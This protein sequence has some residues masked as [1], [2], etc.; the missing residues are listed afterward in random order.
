MKIAIVTGGSRGLGKS[1][2]LHLAQKGHDII[3]LT[4]GGSMA[5]ELKCPAGYIFDDTS[6]NSPRVPDVEAFTA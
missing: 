4:A 1:M 5:S 3:L 2:A 6:L